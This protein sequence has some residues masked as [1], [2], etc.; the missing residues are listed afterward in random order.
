[1]DFSKNLRAYHITYLS[2]LPPKDL[3]VDTGAT[4]TVPGEKRGQ[5]KIF[6]WFNDDWVFT[7][8]IDGSDFELKELEDACA[9]LENALKRL[10]KV[11]SNTENEELSSKLSKITSKILQAKDELADEVLGPSRDTEGLK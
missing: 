2:E 9:D 3:K 1:M 10:I 4:V 5:F 6:T 11:S 7:A 8:T